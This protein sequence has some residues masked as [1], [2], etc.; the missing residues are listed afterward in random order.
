VGR[1]DGTELGLKLPLGPSLVATLGSRL[2]LELDTALSK[3]LSFKLGTKLCFLL[4]KELGT[5]L[6]AGALDG[7]ELG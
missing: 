5:Q 4:G 3:R 6:S 2:R 7:I 1:L